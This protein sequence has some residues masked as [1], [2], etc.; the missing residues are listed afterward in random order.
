MKK[1]LRKKIALA[2]AHLPLMKYKVI[3]RNKFMSVRFPGLNKDGIVQ[4][5]EVKH[6]RRAKRA[7][8]SQGWDGVQYYIN[9]MESQLTPAQRLTAHKKKD[10][11]ISNS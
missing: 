6:I 10:L 1:S 11:I 9:K 4:E 8:I 3:H 5:H 2:V 7:Y